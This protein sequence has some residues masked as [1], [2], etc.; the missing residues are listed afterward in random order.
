MQELGPIS[1]K[2]GVILTLFVFLICLWLFQS[3]KF[4]TG[5]ADVVTGDSDAEIHAATP[6]ILVV[7]LT[8]MIP[9]TANPLPGLKAG[10]P[11]EFLMTW[12]YVQK[13]VP[14]GIILLL[15][16]ARLF[17]FLMYFF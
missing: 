7:V 2:E 5:W 8:F 4:F 10:K 15:G 17:S 11:A 12:D 9:S 16:K 6:A 1:Y 14:W 3:P 13:K